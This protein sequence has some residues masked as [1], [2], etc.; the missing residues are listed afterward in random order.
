MLGER[1]DVAVGII[2]DQQSVLIT[3]RHANARQGDLWEF[4]GGKIETGETPY[5][6][7]CRELQEEVGIVVEQAAPLLI[8]DHDYDDGGVRLHFWQ[9]QRFSGQATAKEQQP[10]QWVAREKLN[11]YTFPAA[12]RRI[13]AQLTETCA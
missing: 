7:L 9:V 5:Q 1:L 2:I 8:M 4:P 3:K 12:N 6:A 11:E 13:V 10:M